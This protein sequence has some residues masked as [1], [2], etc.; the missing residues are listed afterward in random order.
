MRKM[1]AIILSIVLLA[2]PIPV[3]RASTFSNVNMTLVPYGPISNKINAEIRVGVYNNSSASDYTVNISITQ[4]GVTYNFAPIS[5]EIDA[6]SNELFRLFID[7]STLSGVYTVKAIV[8][9]AGNVITQLSDNM[10]VIETSSINRSV[11]LVTTAF[12]DPGAFV[13]G[14]YPSQGVS[15]QQDVR[16][17]MDALNNVGIKTIIV[18]YA[19]YVLNGWGAFYPSQIDELTDQVTLV[20]NSTPTEL[21]TPLDFDFLGTI[22]DQAEVNGQKVFIGIGRGT[23]A[24][25]TFDTRA[26]L[27]PES[28]SVLNPVYLQEHVDFAKEVTDEI[29]NL[30]KNYKSFYGWYISHE[31]QDITWANYFYNPVADYMHSIA[32]EKPVL[33]SPAAVTPWLIVDQM[34]IALSNSSVDIFNYQ[35]SVGAGYD[36]TTFTYTYNPQIRINQMDAMYQ[37]YLIEHQN[38]NQNKHFWA[39]IEAWEMTGPEYTN[40][41]AADYLRYKQQLDIVSKYVESISSYETGGFLESPSSA[42]K[43][44][45]QPAIDLYTHYKNY[46]DEFLGD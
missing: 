18:T 16:N 28:Q 8:Q 17:E 5:K 32:P 10:V 1:L 46:Y 11:P 3:A 13:D 25:I 7:T 35:D 20:G 26:W 29:Y 37:K 34:R 9:R 2:I 38:S 15:T 22:L 6:N 41:Y 36:E 42:V 4:N 39:N 44:G 23:D 12:M 33:V 30:Y 45:G 24:W 43:L 14:V 27:R 31:C 19:E 21:I 40:A